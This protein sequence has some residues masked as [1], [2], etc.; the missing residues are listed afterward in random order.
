MRS[1]KLL[2][3][4]LLLLFLSGGYLMQKADVRVE[5]EPPEQLAPGKSKEVL[6]RVHKGDRNG[7][8]K[9]ELEVPEGLKVEAVEKSGAS[10]TFEDHMAKFI[11]MAM[12]EG[13]QFVVRYRLVAK[14]GAKEG[15]RTLKGSFRYLD[16]NKR[17]EVK[18]KKKKVRIEAGKKGKVA[19][20]D[21]GEGPD[22]A[23]SDD[24][25][26]VERKVKKMGAERFKVRLKVK[27]GELEG[28]AKLVDTVPEGFKAIAKKEGGSSF[29][30][31]GN[32][33]KFVWMDLPGKKTLKVRYR[34]V[35]KTATPGRYEIRGGFSYLKDGNTV[36][37]TVAPSGI[38]LGEKE[39][40]TAQGKDEGDA[41]DEKEEGGAEGPSGDVPDPQKGIDYRVQI[42]A[43]HEDVE[44]DHFE[45]VYDYEGDYDIDHHEGWLKYLTGKYEV[46]RKAR[47]KRVHFR[48]N[49]ELPGPFV[50]AYNDGE[51]ITVQE[52]LMITEQEWVQ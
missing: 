39:E 12:P 35:A 48:E 29:S 1:S 7:F 34:L 5:H 24:Q 4:P 13:G 18:L 33:A 52:A 15:K 51:R 31:D 8:A 28:F 42:C 2:S 37:E 36:R 25:V 26:G 27:K 17:K 20:K 32:K 23:G 10:F 50:T 14:E 41:S 22:T 49:Y 6:V 46:Y 3:F 40:K 9:L 45:E 11:W 30:F 21:E 43:G 19:E 38:E 44:E 16:E 47:D